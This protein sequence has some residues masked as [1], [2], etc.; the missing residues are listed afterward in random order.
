MIE[1][2]RSPGAVR[3][4]A[5]G[6]ASLEHLPN[7]RVDRRAHYRSDNLLPPLVVL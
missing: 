3:I 7:R 5:L 6:R 4:V 2:I 1:V